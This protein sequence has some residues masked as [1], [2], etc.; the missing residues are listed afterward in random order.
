MPAAAYRTVREAMADPQLAHRGAF[1][2]VTDAAGTPYDILTAPEFDV[3]NGSSMNLYTAWP[4][5]ENYNKKVLG[6][7]FSAE[8]DATDN[9]FFRLSGDMVEDESDPRQGHRLTPGNLTLREAVGAAGDGDTIIFSTGG[10]VSLTADID[11]LER[12]GFKLNQTGILSRMVGD[13]PFNFFQ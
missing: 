12:I 4:G 8:W 11:I 10:T 3:A 6:A 2:D 5:I 7:R 13:F 9:L 1:Q